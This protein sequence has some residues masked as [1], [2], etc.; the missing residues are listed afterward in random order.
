[1]YALNSKSVINGKNPTEYYSGI[2]FNV[3]NSVAD[4]QA[5]QSASD[6]VLKELN[7]QRASVSGVSLDEEAANMLRFQRPIPPLRKSSRP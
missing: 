2:V 4:A 7:D 6:L 1:M 5:A 3:G